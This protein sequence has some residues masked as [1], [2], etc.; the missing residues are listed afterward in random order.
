MKKILITGAGGT[1]GLETLKSLLTE[2]KYEISVIDL[3][4]NKNKENFNKYKNRINILYGDLADQSLVED[5]VK[6]HD[7]I[8]H[9]A[10]IL[11][12]ITSLNEELAKETELYIT[13]NFVRAINYY[14]P[15]CLFIYTSTTSVYGSKLKSYS[16]SSKVKSEQN[17]FY[18]KY[19]LKA[20]RVVESKIKHYIIVRVPLILGKV[21]SDNLLYS[22]KKDTLISTMT[23]E[24]AGY[25]LSKIVEKYKKFEQTIVNASGGEDFNLTYEELISNLVKN[26][27]FSF[28]ML[29]SLIFFDKNYF[30][31]VCSDSNK[32]NDVLDYQRDT[33]NNY[34]NRIKYTNKNRYISKYLGRLFLIVWERKK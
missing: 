31:P 12:P 11:P 3:Y 30:S 1:V 10:T 4:N 18:T 2:G 32:F 24:D 17:E 26:G 20:E 5:L 14:N 22:I 34:L 21:G 28:K 25:L 15:E 7:I 19:K 16:A 6:S 9:L 29:L 13:E 8:V 23:K 33:M 27:S